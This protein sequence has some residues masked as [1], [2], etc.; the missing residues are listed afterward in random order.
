M[1]PTPH[2]IRSENISGAK[3]KFAVKDNQEG[4]ADADLAVKRFR[5]NTIDSAH[6]RIY[7][8]LPP[9]RLCYFSRTFSTWPIFFWTFPP[10][11]SSW[12]SASK[13]G[14]FVNCSAFS[15][16]L[17]GAPS[18][19]LAPSANSLCRVQGKRTMRGP[20]IQIGN[21]G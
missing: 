9:G 1:E 6:L 21:S 15:L 16:T 19:R 20:D 2:A 12:P 3:A 14:L 7:D 17:P 5:A 4:I 8:A 11:F 10:T 13:S 18:G